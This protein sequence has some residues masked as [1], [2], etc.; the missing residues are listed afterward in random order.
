MLWGE[1]P[2]RLDAPAMADGDQVQVIELCGDRWGELG[3]AGG[4]TAEAANPGTSPP[5]SQEAPPPQGLQGQ[6][7][8]I[9]GTLWPDP[10]PGKVGVH[11]PRVSEGSVRE[12][13]CVYSS[14]SKISQESIYIL[15]ADGE[16]GGQK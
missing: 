3:S 1:V 5:R 14:C 6:L 12:E 11:L 4:P 8:P 9:P 16:V 2:K 15:T 13:A 10:T 7:R